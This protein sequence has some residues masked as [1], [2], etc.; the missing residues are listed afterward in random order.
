M[1]WEDDPN[2]K[3]ML[4]ELLREVPESVE[5]VVADVRCMSGEI[6]DLPELRC[7][8]TGY[9]GE[10]AWIR[11]GRIVALSGPH[12]WESIKPNTHALLSMP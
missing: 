8:L 9:G 4:R 3:T 2:A 11:D 7:K 10:T 12:T 6:G 5:I 1:E